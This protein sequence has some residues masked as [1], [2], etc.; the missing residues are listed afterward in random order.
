MIGGRDLEVDVGADRGGIGGVDIGLVAVD[1]E[2]DVVSGE[3][4][5][6]AR[7]RV[8]EAH[9]LELSDVNWEGRG[10]LHVLAFSSFVGPIGHV[11]EEEDDAP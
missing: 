6:V 8:F 4:C 1:P 11:I 2:A 7:T 9:D 5:I 10:G 3:L